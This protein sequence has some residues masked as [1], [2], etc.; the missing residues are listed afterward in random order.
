MGTVEGVGTREL[1]IR[2][3]TQPVA[4]SS[5]T[6]IEL[7]TQRTIIPIDNLSKCTPP[8]KFSSK[9]FEAT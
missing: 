8:Q 7:P 9:A 2:S 4:G 6:A 1:A 3:H 5:P